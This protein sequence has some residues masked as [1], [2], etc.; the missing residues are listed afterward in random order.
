MCLHSIRNDRHAV[1]AQE[2]FPVTG[3][4]PHHAIQVGETN[5]QEG[6]CKINNH[7]LYLPEDL[8]FCRGK[9]LM[10][11]RKYW[12]LYLLLG[13]SLVTEIFV[14]SIFTHS[15][16]TTSCVIDGYLELLPRLLVESRLLYLPPILPSLI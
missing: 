1:R 10:E 6:D 13:D 7:Y 9:T 4:S 11:R 16:I 8:N 12:P 14:P 3:G 2:T 15:D 5:R